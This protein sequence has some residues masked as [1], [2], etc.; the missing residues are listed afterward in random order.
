[1]R[2]L[3]TLLLASTTAA[4]AHAPPSHHRLTILGGTPAARRLAQIVAHRVGGTTLTSV[5]FRG[6]ERMLVIGSAQPRSLRGEWESELYAGTFAA[7]DERY[8]VPVGGIRTVDSVAPLARVPVFDLYGR[9]PTARQ[10]GALRGRL[11]KAISRSGAALEELHVAATP[12]RAVALTV[13]VADPAA[14]LKHRLLPVLDVLDDTRVPLLG[15]YI[16]VEN[17]SGALVWATSRLPNEG[18]VYTTPALD[19]CS[20]VAHSDAGLSEPPCPSN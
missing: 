13:R 5:R 17:G 8:R 6:P 12:A 18:G 2:L 1:M 11:T 16:G 19:A 4:G 15:F 20:P 7:L 9:L 14:Y 3:V 10:V